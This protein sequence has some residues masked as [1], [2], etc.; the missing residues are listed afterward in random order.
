MPR[1]AEPAEARDPAAA[2][3]EI[4]LRLLTARPR[5][6]AE[7]WDALARKGI[8]ADTAEAVLDRLEEVGLVDDGAFA[9]MWVHSR[10]ANSGLT[11]GALVTELRRKG[12]DEAVARDAADD[13]DSAAEEERARE[14][15]RKKLR[16]QATARDE[17]TAMRRLVGMLA[18]KGYPQGLVIRVA[19]EELAEHGIEAGEIDTIDEQ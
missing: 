12:V 1:Q 9:E 14:L 5:T 15:V 17:A 7:L 19:R 16:G 8:G 2:A 3:K 18:R 4:C 10:H 6:R 11:R 13:V